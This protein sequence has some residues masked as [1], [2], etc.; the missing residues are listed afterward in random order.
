MLS[1]MSL[2]MKTKEMKDYGKEKKG[3]ELEKLETILTI[4]TILTPKNR[5]KQYIQDVPRAMHSAQM[6][7]WESIKQK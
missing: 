4:L 2:Q 5:K 1:I 6:E 7:I 3:R